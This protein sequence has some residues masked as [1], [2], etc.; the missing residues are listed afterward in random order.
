[1]DRNT[2]N[3]IPK[4]KDSIWLINAT[5]VDCDMYFIQP[6][7]TELGGNS[8]GGF[9]TGYVID[10]KDVSEAIWFEFLINNTAYFFFTTRSGDLHH[11]F[12]I[13]RYFD[14]VTHER[15]RFVVMLRVVWEQINGVAT[16]TPFPHWP[17]V[18][19][20]PV[21][22]VFAGQ[23][24]IAVSYEVWKEK[25]KQYQQRGGIRHGRSAYRNDE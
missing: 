13:S 11:D 1:M 22:F 17:E 24:W 6:G 4:I 18:L 16:P 3:L 21:V 25:I 9:R 5:G 10:V 12:Y 8:G 2:N 14:P 20:Q 7:F 15:P 23:E 19:R